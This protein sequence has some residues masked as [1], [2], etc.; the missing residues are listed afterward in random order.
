MNTTQ[1]PLFPLHTVLFPGGPLPL[2]VFEARYLDMISSCMKT[3]TGFGVSRIREGK[4]VGEVAAAF[5]TGTLAHITDWH[6][7]HDGLLG[8]TVH[9]HRRFRIA[10]VHVEPSQL[11]IARVELLPEEIEVD[12]PDEY[13]PLVDM[14]RRI[15]DQVHQYS[16]LPRRYADATWVSYRLAELLPIGLEKKQLILE[17]DDPIQRLE[18]LMHTLEGLQIY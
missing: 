3:D 4:E 8:V 9:G 15:I 2:R 7:R 1:I 17:M 11:S 14:L 16:E 18:Y 10:S 6:M 12:L 13:L 5:E